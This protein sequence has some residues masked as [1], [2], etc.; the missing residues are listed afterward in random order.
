MMDTN[1]RQALNTVIADKSIDGALVF[2]QGPGTAKHVFSFY[3]DDQPYD[4]I[5][6]FMSEFGHEFAVAV[7]LEKYCYRTLEP[8]LS[9]RNGRVWFISTA[10]IFR[11]IDGG[12]E[13]LSHL[14]FESQ[15]DAVAFAAKSV[16]RM[17]NVSAEI[18]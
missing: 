2:R 14:V 16:A 7:R 9:D 3:D 8:M 10:G 5:S 12:S 13:T 11:T 6:D 18:E 15:D 4:G 1:F 17:T